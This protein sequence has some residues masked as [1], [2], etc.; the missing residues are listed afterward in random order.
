MYGFLLVLQVISIVIL[1]GEALYVF[2]HLNSRMH[3][4]LFLYL[5]SN[6]VNQV[7]YFFEMTAGSLDE[8]YLATRLLYLGKVFIPVSMIIFILL[9]CRINV[10]K[11][12][13]A[14][15][16]SLHAFSWLLIATNDYHH[17]FYTTIGY[18]RSGLFAHN[19]YGHGPVYYLYQMVAP[20][21]AIIDIVFALKMRKNFSDKIAKRHFEIF[22]AAPLIPLLGFIIFLSGR[23]NGYDSTNLGFFI[24]SLLLMIAFFRFDLI[25][26]EDMVRNDVI[27][28]INDGIIATGYNGKLVYF[29]K[30]ARGLFP[31]MLNSKTDEDSGI[32]VDL[33]NKAIRKET[34]AIGQ[35]VYRIVVKDVVRDELYSGR[36][37][38]LDEVTDA[39]R[40]TRQVEEER[41]KAYEANE[42]KSRFLSNM[43]HEIRTP[44][45]AIVGMTDIM[46]RDEL[47]DRDRE[48]LNNI[49]NSGN[50]L[51]DIINDI[52]D[53]SK[54][55]SGKMEI[56]EV[57]YEP[58]TMVND[59]KMI[60]ITRIG[61]KPIRLTYDI[62]HEL[63]ARLVGD[64]VRI[65]QIIINLVNNAIKFTEVGYVRLKLTAKKTSEDMIELGISIKDSGLGIRDEDKARLF[66]SFTQVD[67][68]K[69]H[70]KE[71]T[72]LGLTITKQL[73]ELMGGSI[74]V[75]S[76]YGN[77]SEFF[78]N[79]PQKIDDPTPASE[80][81][82]HREERSDIKF[83]APDAHILIAEDNEINVKVI[84]GLLDPLRMRMDVAENGLN[85]L[86]MIT[87]VRYDLVLMDHMMPVM[88]GV[89]ATMKIRERGGDYY[90]KLPIIALTANAVQGAREE[91]ISS[92]MNDY[93]MKPVDI[94][95]L[96]AKIKKWL[97]SDLVINLDEESE[98][99]EAAPE[100]AY[101]EIPE[102]RD[103]TEGPGGKESEYGYLDRNIGLKHCG[104]EALY[105]EVLQDFYKLIDNKAG[106][107][108]T[109]YNEDNIDEYT[110]EV[111]ALKSVA[112]MVGAEYL[113]G[114]AL[115]L[116]MAGK[117][118]NKALID[119][120]T[121]ELLARY[122]AYKDTLS[123]FDEGEEDNKSEADDDKLIELL[124]RMKE[125]A[126][127]FDIDTV[128]EIMAE[129]NG[130]RMPDE[131]RT[132]MI[133]E[134]DALVRDVA[135]DDVIKSVDEIIA[136]F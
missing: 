90:E 129:L 84:K 116:E 72:G 3:S 110:I 69:N 54:I 37:Y 60:F 51:I 117:E 70:S 98:L 71:G 30:R 96:Y 120:K 1:F 45:N 104:S 105:N 75:E 89:E 94:N 21:Y 119:E 29:N 5:I 73:V 61:E 132:Q 53:F 102:S 17:L 112:R 66:D 24:T 48:Y 79:I 28:N 64:Q 33:R 97:P 62:D 121:P 108:E 14:L 8:A 39:I 22:I 10:P 86:R 52:L 23:T 125:A 6:L 88:D 38:I 134:L 135:Y 46:L 76:Q 27:D 20:V 77:G 58:L 82:Y 111:H 131:E 78:V 4:F 16:I 74:Y 2:F 101:S 115:E 26:T 47:P 36:L 123:Y 9:F 41:E 127:T 85:A 68:V 109:L 44:M 87:D 35:E 12:L 11:W 67:S 130:Y 122:R 128:D 57:S 34:I 25:D 124:N 136:K 113:S 100:E 50:A 92:G 32:I 15:L 55:E 7:G 114:L 83:I 49:R 42:A 31:G 133:R 63:P 18:V 95:D 126:N 81:H 99:L 19:V 43:S 118:G 59:L 107:I 56:T 40:Y 93:V 65:R 91:L 106:R 80:Y 13:C 103:I